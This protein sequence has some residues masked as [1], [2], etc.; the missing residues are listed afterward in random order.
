MTSWVQTITF[1]GLFAS[2]GYADCDACRRL[3]RLT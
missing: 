2:G 1:V 3:A